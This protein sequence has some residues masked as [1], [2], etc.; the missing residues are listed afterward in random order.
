MKFF[1]LDKPVWQILLLSF[2]AVVWGSSFILMKRGLESF[3]NIQVACLRISIAFIALSPILVRN[4]NKIK[5]SQWFP[6]FIAGLLGAVFPAFLF[7]TA[8]TQLS[9]SLTGMLNSL[10]PLF[11]VI[12]G[13]IFFRMQ[14]RILKILGIGIGLL[15]AIGLILGQNSLLTGEKLSLSY[16]TVPYALLVVLATVSYATNV[17]F[18]KKFLKDV[19]AVNITAFGFLIPSP[20]ALAYLFSATDFTQ[21]LSDDPSA[22]QN[23]FYIAVLA[24]F[25]TSL[26]VILFNILIKKVSPVFAS[27]VTY[28]IPIF[29]MVWGLID[30]ETVSLVQVLSIFVILIGVFIV[31]KDN[32]KEK[33]ELQLAAENK[34]LAEAKKE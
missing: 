29:A 26:A 8:Q 32:S 14:V 9:S 30:G 2:L 3:D 21:K 33:K 25:S 22:P 17:N 13:I 12:I 5:K 18:I 31:N 19:S 10:V 34:T 11:T 15:G 20:I 16:Q 28:I 27:S 4:F 24:I 6:L 1:D 7:T 23:L